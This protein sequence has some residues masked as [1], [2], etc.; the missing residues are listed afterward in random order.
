MNREKQS[1]WRCYRSREDIRRYGNNGCGG[2]GYYHKRHIWK[3]IEGAILVETKDG[4]EI[5]KVNNN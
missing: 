5:K 2:M 3:P 4:W 1:C